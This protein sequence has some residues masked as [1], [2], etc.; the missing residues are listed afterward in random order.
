MRGLRSTIVLAVVLIGL[1]AYS[2]FYASKQSTSASDTKE[3][4]FAGLQPDKIDELRIKSASGDVTTLKKG[5]SG[6][7]ITQPIHTR[8][9][10][11]EV[12]SVTSTLGSVEVQRVVEAQPSTLKDYGL[13]SPRIDVGFKTAADKDYRHFLIGDKTA[14]NA[15]LFAKTGADRRVVTI[16]A[17]TESSFNRGTFDLR[18]KTALR[19]DRD[20]IEGVDITAD[21]KTLDL[22]RQGGDW[23]IAK[24]IQAPAD[25]GTAE[26]LV[27]R[28]QTLQMKSI[29]T[30]EPN[31]ADIKKYGLDKPQASVT[32]AFGSARAT[33]DIGSS[34]D[35]GSLYGRDS[36]K[37]VVF[38]VEK[39]I[40]DELKKGAGDFRRKDIFEFR[41]FNATRF[42]IARGGQTVT[43]EHVKG[44]G[45]DAA[46]KWRR[47]APNP[48]DVNKDTME[49][50]LT[51]WANLRAAS[52]VD[53]TAK[54]GLDKP[55]A[56]VTVKFSDGAKEERVTFG[57]SGSDVYAS[58][59]GEPGAAKVDSTDFKQAIKAID[60]IK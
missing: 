9:D 18:D 10:E 30:T 53:S 36:S 4:V 24:P 26:G 14:T 52:F 29:V 15:D 8:A 51:R 1:T 43:F 25:Y 60:D 54:T 42:E 47:V 28:L 41:A 19:F 12:S 7:E 38:T 56:T 46:D 49:A 40:L 21:G 34:A 5:A 33:L 17:F 39:S 22:Q 48:V 57:E 23:K 37:P 13:D 11:G 50:M 20:K 31:P 2:Y 6:W 44:T 35:D 59:T 32:L 45:N 55:A 27:G 16:P 58:R 3:H